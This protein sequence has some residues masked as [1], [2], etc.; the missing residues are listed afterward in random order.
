MA[1]KKAKKGGRKKE[2]RQQEEEGGKKEESKRSRLTGQL[3]GNDG[4][5]N[6]VDRCD[7]RRGNRAESSG[8]VAVPHRLPAVT[9]KPAVNEAGG[10]SR[11]PARSSADRLGQSAQERRLRPVREAS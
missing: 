11:P 9:G 6:A 10:E 5:V 2:I 1:K 8:R 3:R 4:A 7:S